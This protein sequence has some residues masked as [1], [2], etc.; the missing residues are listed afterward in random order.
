M[1]KTLAVRF[2]WMSFTG[3]LVAANIFLSAT[4]LEA[5]AASGGT[6]EFS[7]NVKE[8]YFPV[9]VYSKA[10]NPDVLNSDA[11]WLKQHFD[12]HFWIEGYADIRGDIFYNLVLS[13][14]RS[15]L[16]KTSLTKRGVSDSQIGYATGWGKL[17]PTCAAH[18]EACFQQNRR[19]DMVLP[20]LLPPM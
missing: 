20:E 15:Q 16:V 17:Y 8:V 3:F 4:S 7:Q 9:N 1:R 10:V 14:R 13:Y 19:V 6:S 5:Q 2:A 18:D 12:Q 11:E